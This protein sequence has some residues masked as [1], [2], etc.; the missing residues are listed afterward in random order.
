[1]K[2]KDLISFLKTL[3]PEQDIQL[4]TICECGYSGLME[5]IMCA[6]S[7]NGVT[8]LCADEDGKEECAFR[9]KPGH[10]NFINFVNS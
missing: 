8:Y 10:N 3:P 6:Y 5:D 4:Y 7:E 2:N 9:M 1:M